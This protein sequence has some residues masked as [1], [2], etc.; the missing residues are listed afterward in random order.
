[1]GGRKRGT[2]SLLPLVHIKPVHLIETYTQRNMSLE[3]RMYRT[4][5]RNISKSHKPV[6]LIGPIRLRET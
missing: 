3:L 1:M 2:P 6:R 5:N 4:L